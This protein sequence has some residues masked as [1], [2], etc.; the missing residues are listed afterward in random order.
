MSFEGEQ[1]SRPR[2]PGER[3][4]APAPPRKRAPRSRVTG[5]RA[6]ALG[7]LVLV[8]VVVIAI[9]RNSSSST[10]VKASSTASVTHP[11]TTP[12]TST[13]GGTGSASNGGPGTASVP[14]L[15]YHVINTQPAQST[16]NPAL[17]VPADE[18]SSQMQAL[19]AAGWHAVTLN[20]LAA[21]W[22]RGTSLGSGKPIV[23]TFDNGYASHY[24]N[25]FPVLKH[26]GWVGVENLP[27]TGL[28]P[29]D[30][31]L[32][33]TQIRALIA[34]G[35]ELDSQGLT[36]SPLTGGD[37]TRLTSDLSTARQTLSSR[38]GVPVNWF[39]YPSGSYDATVVAAVRAAGYVGATT[40]SPGWAGPQEDRFRL[41]RLEVPG[42]T[43]PAQ[44]LTQISSAK[45]N[46]SAPPTS[47]GPVTG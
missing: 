13:N 16:A 20:Q 42:G 12:S 27:V 1:R 8:A 31:G 22:A 47:S 34:G 32:S 30:G 26:L 11:S 5:Q 18:F 19:K 25:A 43:T 3:R 10:T 36:S 24:V 33:D 23:I 14:I 4:P 7:A 45:A 21:Y 46:T 6:A 9:V 17:Y 39:A 44:L 29:T 38:Y 2:P 28:P 40:L 37:A 15:V 35:W 41:P